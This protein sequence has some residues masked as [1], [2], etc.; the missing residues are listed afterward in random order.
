MIL[1][2]LMLVSP[3]VPAADTVAARRAVRETES[4]ANRDNGS[5]WHVRI[6]APLL[7][8]DPASRIAVS[9]VPDSAGVLRREG[10][11]YSGKLPD[12]VPVANTGINWS[13]VRWAMVLVPLPADSVERGILLMHESW[14][15]V[16]AKVGIPM[17]TPDN[18]HLEMAAGR[19]WLKVEGRALSQAL[20]TNGAAQRQAAADAIAA[21]Q[22][23][24]A[25]APGSGDTERPLEL[26]EGLAE[27]SG[28]MLVVTPANRAEVGKARLGKLEGTGTLFR[29]FPY[30]TGTAWALLLDSLSPGWRSRLTAGSDLALMAA[31]AIN[32]D[33]AVAHYNEDRFAPYGLP[34]I[35]AAEEARAKSIAARL[36]SLRV[37]FVTGPVLRLPLREMNISFDPNRAEALPGVGTVYQPLRLSD[38]WGELDADGSGALIDASWQ[39]ARVPAAPKATTDGPGWKLQLKEGWE[40]V[41]GE[42]PGD[43]VLKAR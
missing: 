43:F 25:A 22:M 17:V 11:F 15:A 5:L 8:V 1:T 35:R 28:I 18:P 29:S 32:A 31:A 41:A 19:T 4:Y 23:R 13:G 16:Q 38:K 33:T 7:L 36:D 14:H 39:E 12:A 34:A 26:A 2:L 3:Q 30:A 10:A 20:S 24:R 42:R 21:R 37:T 6:S 9:A 40:V 27:Y